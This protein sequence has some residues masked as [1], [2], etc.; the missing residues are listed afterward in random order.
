M[1]S[2]PDMISYVGQHVKCKDY[3]LDG[4]SSRAFGTAQFSDTNPLKPGKVC[5]CVLSSHH[6]STPVHA[7]RWKLVRE[8]TGKHVLV[9]GTAVLA[10]FSCDDREIS[11][12]KARGA[13]E[14]PG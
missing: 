1:L 2:Q 12:K 8:Y 4:L 9:P 11:V 3:A 6:F 5:V 13:G 7:S 14:N 10:Y